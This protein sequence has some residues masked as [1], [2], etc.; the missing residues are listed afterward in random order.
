MS[1]E[2]TKNKAEEN[3]AL[4]NNDYKLLLNIA[5]VMLLIFDVDGLITYANRKAEAVLEMEGAGLIGLNWFDRFVPSKMKNEVMQTSKR[6][7]LG[8]ELIIESNENIVVTAK[9]NSKLIFWSN[10]VIKDANGNITGILSS[11]IDGTK[12]DKD[13][14]KIRQLSTAVEQSSNAIVITDTNGKIEYTNPKFTEVTGFSP[15]EA[16]GKNPSILNSGLQPKSYYQEMWDTLYKGKPWSGEF[17][18][19][20]KNGNLFW[21]QVIISPI[22]GDDG[23]LINFLAIK[24]DVTEKK[25]IEKELE[26]KLEEIEIINANSPVIIWK[27][28]MNEKGEFTNPYISDAVDDFLGLPAG[29]INNDFPKFYEYVDSKYISEVHAILGQAFQNP[30]IKYC[31]EYE[32]ERADGEKAWFSSFGACKVTPQ[33]KKIVYGSTVDISQ[34][35]LVEQNLTEAKEKAE[36]SE[37]KFK[38]FSNQSTEGITVA[39]LAGNYVY[40]NPAFCEMSGYSEKELL[41][42]TV[43]DMKSKDQPQ[44]SF[45]DSKEKFEEIPIAVNLKKK[46]AENY[47]TEITGKVIEVNNESLVLGTIRDVTEKV[48]YQND[49]IESENFLRESQ[50]VALIGSYVLNIALGEWKSS[51]VL[52]EMFGIDKDYLKDIASWVGII[53]PLDKDAMEK[54]LL[55]N[56]LENNEFFDREYRILR[57]DTQELRW[58]HGMGKLE[59]DEQ[60]T[61]IKMKGTIQDITK[62]KIEERELIKAKRVAEEN[63]TRFKALHNASFGGISIHDEG[64][65]VDCNL[66]LSG[67]TG[68]SLNELIGMDGL[69]LIAES[70]RE[71]VMDKIVSGYENAYEALGLRKNG[72]EYFLRLEARN[73]PYKGKQVRV[74]EFRDITEQKLI[75][76]EL[77]LAKQKAEESDLLKTE[78]INNMSHEI[79]TPLNGILGFTDFL[80]QDNLSVN[81]RIKYTKIIQNSGNQLLRIVDDVM[82]I[83]RLGTKQVEL[84][85]NVVSLND[86]CQSHFDLF[87][88]RAKESNLSLLMNTELSTED[89]LV[90]LDD[91]LLS[92]IFNK[93]LDNA[94]KFTEEGSVEFGYSIF[95]GLNKKIEFYVKDT[96][97]GISEENQQS[98]FNRFAQ[99][100]KELNKKVGGLG[101]GL[102]IAAESAKLMGGE[103]TVQSKKGGGSTFLITVPYHPADSNNKSDNAIVLPKDVGVSNK[104]FTVLLVDDEFVNLMYLSLLLSE[105]DYIILEAVNGVEAVEMC[106]SHPEIDLVFMDL[107]MPRMS[108]FDAARI[109][110]ESRPDLPIIAQTAYTTSE[111]ED[112]ALSS[113]CND[114]ISKPINKE[115]VFDKVSKYLEDKK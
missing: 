7:F 93:I 89:S 51:S 108:G 86:L 15:Q 66:G 19:K 115:E 21:E 98:I 56:V 70:S 14:K 1:E 31:M 11:G 74:V 97:V 75:E 49:L 40:V 60:G 41:K 82:E 16:L 103:I 26:N 85:N 72:E 65:I 47:L 81:Q 22:F 37:A 35:K 44:Q 71:T 23:E 45:Y 48:K 92:K 25:K 3:G 87:E 110:K 79:R 6:I 58:L 88:P 96:G 112:E 105:F 20:A 34:Q 107:K 63:E 106:K 32:V 73:I 53:H 29:T 13:N 18:N 76:N 69:L 17:C 43:F 95:Y 101:L 78:F 30:G 8:K 2:S 59:F 38:A 83:S 68:Y 99:E 77:V 12:T 84:K 24:E 39:D 62:R 5:E 91:V 27:T 90:E 46:N 42:L 36:E 113:G 52:D 80:T 9:G 109:I 57:K 102:S 100:E 64:F 114:F 50:K 28:E 4:S 94:L 111:E 33:N 55:I 67:I 10:D 104:I 54:Y 61:L